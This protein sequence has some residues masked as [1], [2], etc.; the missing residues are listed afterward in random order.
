MRKN[1]AKAGT[2]PSWHHDTRLSALKQVPSPNSFQVG[3]GV[4]TEK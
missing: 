4:V 1:V 2:F 3:E